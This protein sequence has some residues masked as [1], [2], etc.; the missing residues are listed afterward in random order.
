MTPAIEALYQSI[1]AELVSIPQEPFERIALYVE[2]E[3]G[4]IS[5]NVFY[6]MPGADK[7]TYRVGSATLEDLIYEMWEQW[8]SLPGQETWRSLLYTVDGGKF[9]IDMTYAEKFNEQ[10]GDVERRHLAIEPVF[11]KR[12]VDYSRA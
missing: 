4:V 12:K 7:I 2:V 5:A 6:A 9:N 1:G 11:G 10:L 8:S 3:E